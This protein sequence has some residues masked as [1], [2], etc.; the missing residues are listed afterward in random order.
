M[1]QFCL[2]GLLRLFYPTILLRHLYQTLRQA[3]FHLCLQAKE[4]YGHV[5]PLFAGT[6]PYIRFYMHKK[7]LSLY[8]TCRNNHKH[9]NH[10]S[11]DFVIAC[12]LL[13]FLFGYESDVTLE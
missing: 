10:Q 11:N 3:G 7:K 2:E 13:A 6:L 9:E 8:V 4:S 5:E 1:H 12:T